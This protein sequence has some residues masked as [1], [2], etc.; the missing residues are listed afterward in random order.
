M[1]PSRALHKPV[2]HAR[3]GDRDAVLE[4]DINSDKV[5]AKDYDTWA[6]EAGVHAEA[7]DAVAALY[8]AFKANDASRISGRLAVR[9][10]KAEM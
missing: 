10:G 3:R 6:Q 2:L 7:R 5:D 1:L 4:F 9:D 8:K